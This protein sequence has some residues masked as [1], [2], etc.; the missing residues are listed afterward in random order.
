MARKD[1]TS[2]RQNG[3]YLKKV[4]LRIRR[5]E[6]AI[7]NQTNGNISGIASGSIVINPTIAGVG[8]I[9][10]AFDATNGNDGNFSGA[11]SGGGT[12]SGFKSPNSAVV[13]LQ[14]GGYLTTNSVTITASGGTSPYTYLW[15][16][17]SGD[18]VTINSPT[19]NTTSFSAT[20]ND[21]ETKNAIYKCT[22]TDDVAATFD[23]QVN[24]TITAPLDYS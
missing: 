12:L 14:G 6:A 23:V 4:S 15:T 24:I 16:K 18:T 9:S 8:K 3:R 17:V 21:G 5:Q 1:R 22:I 19:S 13:G 20:V 11:L 10:D 7:A 2:L